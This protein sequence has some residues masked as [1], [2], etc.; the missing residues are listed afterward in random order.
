MQECIW[1]DMEFRNF[2]S[3]IVECNLVRYNARNRVVLKDSTVQYSAVQYSTVQYITSQHSTAQHCT[4][5]HCTAQNKI[6]DKTAQYNTVQ[7]SVIQYDTCI[8]LISGRE[9]PFNATC[10][11]RYTHALPTARK[12]IS[13]NRGTRTA[14]RVCAVLT[15]STVRSPSPPSPPLSKIKFH[16]IYHIK[17][18]THLY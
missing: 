5:L 12:Q 13:D 15:P 3:L 2:Y 4:A 18:C 9:P 17:K 1:V 8:H 14:V 7:C 16:N 6:Q 11:D 10:S